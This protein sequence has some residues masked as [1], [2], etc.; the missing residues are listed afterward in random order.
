MSW[1]P[2]RVDEGLDSA[3]MVRHLKGSCLD[4]DRHALSVSADDVLAALQQGKGVDLQGVV[5]VGDLTFDDL[6][7]TPLTSALTDVPEIAKRLTAERVSAVRVINGP[8]RLEDVE[9]RG[10]LA[11]NQD[12]TGYVLVRGPVT[13]RGAVMQRAL[14]FSRMIFLDRADFSGMRIGYEG[15]F[16]QAI[17]ADDADF[18]RTDFGTHSRF[19]QA[20]FVEHVAFTGATFHGLAEFLEVSFA[21]DAEFSQV[22]YAQGTGFSG[23]RFHRVAHFAGARFEREVYFRFTDFQGKANFQRAHFRNTADFTEA[24]FGG[25]TD[26]REVVSDT[27][28]KTF[29]V[30]FPERSEAVSGIWNPVYWLA[31]GVLGLLCLAALLLWKRTTR[32]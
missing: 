9:V 18:T 28:T 22:R 7:L 30:E 2:C 32:P 29:G 16:M 3:V 23:S 5:L 6:P 21:G 20:R 15:F 1:G 25:G 31:G 19:H 10:I 24:R 12:K 11:S 17:F 27:P 26:F 13:M 14:D 8:F 4:E